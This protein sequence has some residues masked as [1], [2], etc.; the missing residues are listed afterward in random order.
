M[1]GREFVGQRLQIMAPHADIRGGGRGI[2]CRLSGSLEYHMGNSDARDDRPDAADRSGEATLRGDGLEG[3]EQRRA[4]DHAA[5]EKKRNP[6]RVV[7][8]DGEKDTLYK[9]G[10]DTDDAESPP[11]GTSSP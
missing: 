3:S 6:D 10:L 9:D 4:A 11:M 7:R 8:V 2:R 5:Y 1:Y